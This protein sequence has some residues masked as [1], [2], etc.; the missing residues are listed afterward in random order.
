MNYIWNYNLVTLITN[1]SIYSVSGFEKV[2]KKTESREKEPHNRTFNNP[3]GKYK[4]DKLGE[5]SSC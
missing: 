4:T 5:Q 2:Y 3:R 1:L